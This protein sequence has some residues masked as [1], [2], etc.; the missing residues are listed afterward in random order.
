MVLDPFISLVLCETY[1]QTSCHVSGRYRNGNGFVLRTEL[2]SE[3]LN[4]LIMD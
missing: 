4:T 2:P 3:L 1:H